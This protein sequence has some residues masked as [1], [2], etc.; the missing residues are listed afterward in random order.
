MVEAGMKA[1]KWNKGL[2]TPFQIMCNDEHHTWK[3]SLKPTVIWTNNICLDCFTAQHNAEFCYQ[4]SQCSRISQ[5][6]TPV[7]C[8]LYV[9]GSHS[10]SNNVLKK[11]T[12]YKVR[13]GKGLY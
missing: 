8:K 6:P 10:K 12:E 1:G 11:S 9:T 2:P 7:A 3:P 4:Q 5:L 13:E